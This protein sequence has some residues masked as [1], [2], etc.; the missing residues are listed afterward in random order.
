MY[1]KFDNEEDALA[2]VTKHASDKSKQPREL[3]TFWAR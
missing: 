2:F 3:I 1:K